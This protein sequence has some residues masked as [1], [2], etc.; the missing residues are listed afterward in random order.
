MITKNVTLTLQALLAAFLLPI[1]LVLVQLEAQ[2]AGY[3]SLQAS[4]TVTPPSFAVSYQAALALVASIEAAIGLGIAPPTLNVQLSAVADLAL[5]LNLLVGKL[6]AMTLQ[7]TVQFLEYQGPT[8][9]LGGAV[10]GALP[11][12]PGGTYAV[13]LACS[14]GDSVT[15]ASLQTVFKP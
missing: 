12:M 15:V 8:S 1:A 3:V 10:Q 13:V 11:T 5:A 2:L 9:G 7:G 14:A 4:L 6:K